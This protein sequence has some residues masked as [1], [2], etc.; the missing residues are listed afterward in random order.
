MIGKG[1]PEAENIHFE[2]LRARVFE[3]LYKP[4]LVK[5]SFSI[6]LAEMK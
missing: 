4:A 1:V 2:F 6:F 5:H 3:G